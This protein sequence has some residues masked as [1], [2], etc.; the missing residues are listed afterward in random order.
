MILKNE[1]IYLQV[2]YNY[3]PGPIRH[4]HNLPPALSQNPQQ[5]QRNNNQQMFQNMQQQNHHRPR[6]DS[7]NYNRHQHQKDR[8]D[9]PKDEFAGLMTPREKQWLLN[10]QM[11]QLNTGTPFFDDYYYTVSNYNIIIFM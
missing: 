2:P 1:Y 6:H 3:H 10:I 11:L 7:G 9:L 5:L 4:P 8:E